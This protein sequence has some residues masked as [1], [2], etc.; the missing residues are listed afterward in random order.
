MPLAR[1][2]L[3]AVSAALLLAPAVAFGLTAVAA[4]APLPAAATPRAAS[5]SPGDKPETGM[6]GRIPPADIASGRAAEGYTCNATEV[7][8]FPSLAGW[9]VEKYGECAYYNGDPGGLPLGV[10]NIDVRNPAPL[11][12]GAVPLGVHVMDVSDPTEPVET[13]FLRSPAMQSPHEAMSLNE[14]RGLLVGV[15]G[16]AVQAPGVLE[17][18]DLKTDCTN[19]RLLNSLVDGVPLAPNQ[20]AR[21][22][23]EGQFSAD[24]RTYYAAGGGGITAVDLTDPAAPAFLV[25]DDTINSHGL[26]TSADGR[27]LYS[28]ILGDPLVGM[29]VFDVSSIQDRE[30][31]P[32]FEPLGRVSWP[33]KSI[34]QNTIP[35]TIGGRSLLVES[36]EFGG[37]GTLE[38]AN[39]PE[40]DVGAARLLDVADPRNPTVVS[41]LR[42]EV[43][44]RDV[45]AELAED[46]SPLLGGPYTGHYCSV[47]QQVEPGI[48]ACSML[49]SGL[50][51]FDVR[52]PEAPREVAYF[53][54]P[55][56]Q[57]T[58]DGLLKGRFDPTQPTRAGLHVGGT[59]EFVPERRE[60]WV[61]GQET[62]FHVIRLAAAAWPTAAGAP[63]AAPA[64]AAPAPAPAA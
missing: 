41:N 26:S 58:Q 42:L 15:L 40:G 22:G 1:P 31:N 47:P 11:P 53:S 28:A 7:G 46:T 23:H 61:S 16:N 10:A 64:P 14:E 54:P 4:E 56:T 48:V 33:E 39:D 50:R 44:Q 63:A 18:Y 38:V 29:A 34:P 17:V 55:A 8:H 35:V 20:E 25:Q 32:R 36:D 2:R 43:H 52:D 30:A 62:G 21:I 19:P 37:R 12:G 45:Q 3:V 24:G 57:N 5:C 59:V 60:I 13:A 9:R 27:L 6:Q 51:I 49:R